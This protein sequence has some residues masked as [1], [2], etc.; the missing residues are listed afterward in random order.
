VE[1]RQQRFRS[2]TSSSHAQLCHCSL[3]MPPSTP[4]QSHVACCA[5]PLHLSCP[6]GN[7]QDRQQQGVTMQLVTRHPARGHLCRPQP[8]QQQ[9]AALGSKAGQLPM[10]CR[11]IK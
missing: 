8:L 5:G 4:S 7:Y 10:E 2:H 1:N 11:S 3:H 6:Q 9:G